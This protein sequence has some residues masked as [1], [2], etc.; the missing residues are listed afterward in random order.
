MSALEQAPAQRSTTAQ[1]L[2]PPS[3]ARQ[4]QFGVRLYPFSKGATVRVELGT[5]GCLSSVESDGKSRLVRCRTL[6]WV[7]LAMLVSACGLN[8]R[9]KAVAE[10][11]AQIEVVYRQSEVLART[12]YELPDEPTGPEAF[13]PLLGAY[14]AYRQEVDRLN[15]MLHRLGGLVPE[16]NEHLRSHFDPETEDALDRCESAIE[17]FESP[18]A[19]ETEY[20]EALTAIC[21]CVERY[22]A[23]VT[24]VSQQYARLAG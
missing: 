19:T 15:V 24:A 10:T 7:I 4:R 14:T 8:Q 12:I 9:E 23:A 5:T 17:I 13:T 11:N 2:P 18:A 21:L 22:A 1:P 20:Q 3:I 6:A 16:L